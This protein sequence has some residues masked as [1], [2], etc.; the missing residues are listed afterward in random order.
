MKYFK[1]LLYFYKIRLEEIKKGSM[2]ESDQK[3]I[4]FNKIMNFEKINL[5]LEKL[6]KLISF[7]TERQFNLILSILEDSRFFKKK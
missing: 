3:I 6:T 7:F 2:N 5:N 1:K 4:E